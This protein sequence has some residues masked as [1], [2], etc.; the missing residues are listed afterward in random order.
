MKFHCELLESEVFEVAGSKKEKGT[1][2]F[3]YR[4]C[5]YTTGFFFI[6]GYVKNIMLR[7]VNFVRKLSQNKVSAFN[8]LNISHW[9]VERFGTQFFSIPV[10]E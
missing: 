1:I 9:F 7:T 4:F 10:C 2:G 3:N 6:N 8:C 5:R